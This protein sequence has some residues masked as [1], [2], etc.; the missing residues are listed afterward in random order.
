MSLVCLVCAVVHKYVK[1]PDGNSREKAP[2]PA[3]SFLQLG[4]KK[5]ITAIRSYNVHV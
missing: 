5:I 1:F 4:V 3:T 2:S